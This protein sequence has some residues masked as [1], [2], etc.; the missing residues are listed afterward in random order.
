MRAASGWFCDQV[1]PSVLWH[2]MQALQHAAM[3]EAVRP[4]RE[5]VGIVPGIVVGAAYTYA[6]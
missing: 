5:V 4:L 2:R 3:S 6:G 1:K